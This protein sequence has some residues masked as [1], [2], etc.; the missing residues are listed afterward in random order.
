MDD[1]R[2]FLSGAVSKTIMQGRYGC[3]CRVQEKTLVHLVF[4]KKNRHICH[5][6]YD[7]PIARVMFEHPYSHPEIS[8]EISKERR[9]P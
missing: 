2:E 4:V 6:K 5:K 7:K 1:I 9:L 3:M 8:Q